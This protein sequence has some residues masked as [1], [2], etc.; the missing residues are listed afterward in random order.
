MPLSPGQVIN[1]RY[2]IVKTLGQGGFGVVYR[3][4]DAS[5]DCPR[6][7]KEN[8]DTSPEARRQFKREAQFLTVISHPN[9]PKVIDHFIIPGQGQDLQ[10]M[11]DERRGPL[12]EEQALPWIEQICDALE[13]LHA[14]VPQVIHRDI[15][16]ANIRI[17]PAG[18]AFLV[19]FGLA[20]AYD[21]NLQTTLGARAVT[22]GFSPP[23]QYG[24]GT[25][26]ARSDVYAL[27]A[28]LYAVLSRQKPPAS[29]DI[30]ANSALKPVPL[31]TLNP[32]VSPEV[33]A[34][35]ACAMQTDRL[36]RFGS[37]AE[38]RQALKPAV[39]SISRPAP[40]A[41]AA[42]YR[43]GRAIPAAPPAPQRR[44]LLGATAALAIVALLIVIGAG[45][46]WELRRSNE[47]AL[48]ALTQT[49][50]AMLAVKS[51]RTAAPATAIATL[52]PTDTPTMT[53]TALLPTETA[54]PT[55]TPELNQIGAPTV[56]LQLISSSTSFIRY[57]PAISACYFIDLECWIVSDPNYGTH[58]TL[59]AKEN[60]LIDPLWTNPTLTFWHRYGE[61]NGSTLSL[62][63]GKNNYI[64]QSYRNTKGWHEEAFSLKDYSGRSISISFI[65]SNCGTAYGYESCNG[66]YWAIQNARIIPDYVAATPTP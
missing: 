20:K 38:F 16:P 31:H 29:V 53:G 58:P 50:E 28:T 37:V 43:V 51:E 62:S 10:E 57:P 65:A 25:T 40:T 14:Q 45:I 34:A 60:V 63:D 41:V 39:V 23:E 5:L 8:L 18:R 4:W 44:L 56:H 2:R 42:P 61:L 19:D 21:A 3:A 32:Q 26:D 36:G 7:I 9:L 30:V 47:T 22:P 64:L 48:Q 66:Y 6:A 27:G 1:N 54:N 11:L 24:L 12:P 17:T 13:Y 55:Q 52:Q 35:V 49:A 33:S 59:Q 46:W 15:K